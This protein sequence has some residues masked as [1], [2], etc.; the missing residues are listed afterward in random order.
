MGND[1]RR[2][3]ED[4]KERLSEAVKAD[5]AGAIRDNSEVLVGMAD[6]NFK[7]T[8][9]AAK[10]ELDRKHQQFEGLAKPLSSG[11]EICSTREGR[12]RGSGGR[13]R[14]AVTT[15]SD[16]MPRRTRMAW[17]GYSLIVPPET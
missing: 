1:A 16:G 6:E 2:A 15:L 11:Y 10:G 7:K 9:A 3:I 5:V 14:S 4:A 8:M 12:R 13:T 17:S